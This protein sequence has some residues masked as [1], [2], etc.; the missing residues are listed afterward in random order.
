[1]MSACLPR[2]MSA[3]STVPAVKKGLL[4]LMRCAPNTSVGTD[5]PSESQMSE[6]PR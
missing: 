4:I 3:L 6:S 2:S 1:M 5:Y